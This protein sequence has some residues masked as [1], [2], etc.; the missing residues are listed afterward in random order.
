LLGFQTTAKT[1]GE[2]PTAATI[3]IDIEDEAVKKDK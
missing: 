3:V 2:F 1:A